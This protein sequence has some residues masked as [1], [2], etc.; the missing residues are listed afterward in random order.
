MPAYIVYNKLTGSIIKSGI[1]SGDPAIQIENP[2][3]E[4][5]ILSDHPT[6]GFKINPLTETIE[7]CEVV[8]TIFDVI[9]ML[10]EPDEILNPLISKIDPDVMAWRYQNWCALRYNSYPDP[11]EVNDGNAKLTAGDPTI[12]AAGQAQLDKYYADC[13]AVKVRFPKQI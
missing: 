3:T 12:Q 13:L 4:D 6:H 1:S 7:D 11:K 8:P 2:E 9:A 10:H 5:Y